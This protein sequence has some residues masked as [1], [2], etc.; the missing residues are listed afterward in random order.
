MFNATLT[1]R[2]LIKRADG[3]EIG[4]EVIGGHYKTAAAAI[5]QVVAH[6]G[7]EKAGPWRLGL[8]KMPRSCNG[9]LQEAVDA[10]CCL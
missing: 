1:K 8:G 5:N 2:M 9:R 4:P 6:V 3:Q 7:P 10:D